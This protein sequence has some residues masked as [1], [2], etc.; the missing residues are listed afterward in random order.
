M[1]NIL[2]TI[3][4]LFVSCSSVFAIDWQ[5]VTNRFGDRAYVDIDSIKL[6]KNYYFY[7]IKVLNTY[8]NKDVIITMQSRKRGGMSARIKFYEVDEYEG[9]NGDYEHITDN[10]SSKLETV[11]F[12]SLA[13]KCY[14]LVNSVM[15]NRQVQIQ[16]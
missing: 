1:R 13:E 11:E 2:I 6:Y 9:L 8:T 14:S 12:G 3:I 5:E 7:N 15:I 4:V 10:F 16:F